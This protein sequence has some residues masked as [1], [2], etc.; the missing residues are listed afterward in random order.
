MDSSSE[1]SRS[2]RSRKRRHTSKDKKSS[3]HHRSRSHH[4]HSSKK[5]SKE[6]KHRSK[7]SEKSKKEIKKS[8]EKSK[9][10]HSKHSS[11]KSDH[12]SRNKSKHSS[13]SS[14]N[15][16]SLKENLLDNNDINLKYNIGFKPNMFLPPM[17][18]N[19]FKFSNMNNNNNNM[20]PSNLINI[21]QPIN[22][23]IMGMGVNEGLNDKIVKD[24]NFLNSEEKLFENIVNHEMSM[25]NLFSDCQ[26]SE[27]YLGK[28]LYRTIKKHTYDNNIVI[29]D[30]GE[31]E[32]KNFVMPKQS[33]II[34]KKIEDLKINI[35]KIKFEGLNEIY[36]KLID[37]RRNEIEKENNI[38]K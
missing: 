19:Q 28:T 4:H 25:K 5:K 37:E 7:D 30:E 23:M 29:I 34:Q 32:G 26:F 3:H 9:T 14:Q 16:K 13:S 27:K 18:S 35:Q 15:N 8:K 22:P 17:N 36:K 12:S 10:H 21:Q 6:S 1:D 31:D 20:F 11:Y 24:Q 2:S 38:N 33:E